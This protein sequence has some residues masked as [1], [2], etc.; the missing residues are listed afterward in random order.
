MADETARTMEDFACAHD[1]PGSR[2]QVGI[3]GLETVLGNGNRRH[4][5]VCLDR[6][7]SRIT[8][9]KMLVQSCDQAIWPENSRL[10]GESA[11]NVLQSMILISK[12][13][14]SVRYSDIMKHTL[15]LRSMEV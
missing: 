10:S 2:Q 3:R 1:A 8:S 4:G 12:R 7:T 6:E 13:K 9:D 11:N 14:E 5:R 15:L